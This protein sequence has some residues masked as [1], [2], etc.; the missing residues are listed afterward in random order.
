M[1]EL[2]ALAP[3][4]RASFARIA[5]L[6]A[7]QGLDAVGMPHVKHLEGPLWEM[8]MRGRDNIARRLR[9]GRR[10]TRRRRARVCEEDPEDARARPRDRPQAGKGSDVMAIPVENAIR[11]WMKDPEFKAEYDALGPEF[12][13]AEAM[14]EAR[15]R[16]GLSQAQVAEKMGT[17]QPVVA[18]L[19]SGRASPTFATLLSFGKAVGQKLVVAF[20]PQRAAA[21]SRSEPQRAAASGRGHADTSTV[22]VRAA[23]KGSGSAGTRGARATVARAAVARATV[24]R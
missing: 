17:R 13:L 12:A 8:R 21:A 6:I 11:R 2:E 3:D 5:E 16:A 14:I 4:V 1:A 24:T 19:E 15:K 23:A 20:E 10:P 18:R 7:S 9:E 22:R